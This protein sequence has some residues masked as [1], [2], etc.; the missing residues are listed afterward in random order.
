MRLVLALVLLSASALTSALRAQAPLPFSA[1]LAEARSR[2]EAQALDDAAILGESLRADADAAGDRL[3]SAQASRL[4]GSV[5][6][7]QE[8]FPEA[9]DALRRAQALFREAGARRFE[10]ETDLLYARTLTY[11]GHAAEAVRLALPA[12]SEL[13]ALAIPREAMLAAYS[14]TLSVLRREPPGDEIRERARVL[15]KPDDR[16]PVACSLWQSLGDAEFSDADYAG[17]HESLTQALACYEALG[18]R[19]S[20]GRVLVSLGRVQRAHGQLHTAMDYYVRAAALQKAVGDM[21]AWLQSVNAQAVTHDRLGQFT[22]AEALYRQALAVARREKLTRYEMFLQGNLGGSLLSSGRAA[23]AL[24]ELEA[25]V[26]RETSAELRTIRHRQIAGAHADLGR[27]DT[28]LRHL[29]TAR[30]LAVNPPFDD[31]VHWLNQRA[32]VLAALGR[33]DEAKRDLGEAVRL[34]EDARERVLAGDATRHGFGDLH[35]DTFA[36]SIDVAMRKD[37]VAAA[38]EL[39]E[40]ARARALLDL[41]QARDA[42]PGSAPPGIAAMQALARDFDT[43]FLVYWVQQR[44]TFAWVVS[45]NGVYGERL[46]VGERQLRQWVRS[47]AGAGDV[48]AGINAALLGG[49][50]LRPWRALHRAILA[51]LAHRLPTR[52]A[53]RLTIVPH[54]PLLHLPFAGLLDARGRHL[55]ERH[56]INY[57][58]SIAVLQAAS[59]RRLAGGAGAGALVLGDPAPLPRLPGVELPPPLPHARLEARRVAARFRSGALLSVGGAATEQTLRAQVGNYPLLHVATHARVSEEATAPSYLLLARGGG[60]AEDD[61]LLTSEEVKALPLDGATVVLSACGTALGR[62][63]GEGTLGF[64]RSFLA[65][66]ARA[67]VATTWE[68]PDSAGLRTMNAFY[69]TLLKGSGIASALRTAQLQQLQALRAGRLST[70]VGKQLVTLPA[71]PLLWAGYVAV[72]VD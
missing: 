60:G 38:L 15:L 3:V 1:R 7:E 42:T 56:T 31:R 63:T 55:V 58:P 35:Q 32:T 48:P 22:R 68:M 5:R 36:A 65:A 46:R 37:D 11:Q 24:V 64:T 4:L 54:G 14:Q 2:F 43:T 71:T 39:A 33:L 72:G 17:A 44:T 40:Q 45:G 61:G 9:Q 47:A 67:V 23:Q 70:R 50:D 18:R 66:G 59:R 12:L 53:S 41:V 51:P 62:V 21:P 20:A 52:V 26:T 57:A 29:E 49:P 25:V 30:E 8:R 10:L 16:F 6:I 69:A 13:E 19:S 28:A 34:I 27:L